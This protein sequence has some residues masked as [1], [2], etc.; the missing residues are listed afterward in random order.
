MKQIFVKRLLIAGLAIIT[1]PSVVLAQKEKTKD[2]KDEKE[3]QTIV[4]TRNGNLD[5]KTVIEN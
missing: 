2:T 3:M 1:V 4:I 5:K